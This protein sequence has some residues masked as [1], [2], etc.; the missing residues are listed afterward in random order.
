MMSPQQNLLDVDA[1]TISYKINNT[2]IPAVRDFRLQLQP[3]QI[4]GLVGESGSGK[5]TIAMACMRYLSANGRIEAGSRLNF[6]GEDLLQA[7]MRPL[8]AKRI[9]LVPQ[10]AP[11]ALNPSIKIGAQVTEVLTAA[12][13]IDQTAAHDAMTQ[14]FQDVNLLDAEKVARRYPHE[15]SGGMQQRVLIAMALITN[16]Q[17]LI[18][19][20]PTTGL[21]V[22]TEAVILD[23]IREL[24][25]R[26][27]TGLIYI[28]HNL[29]VVAQLC[30][31]VLVLYGG[32]IMED[33]GVHELYQ[34][35]WHPYSAGLLRSIPKPG[36]NKGDSQLQSIG[37][38]PPAL[39]QLPRGCVFAERCP[40]AIELCHETKPSLEKSAENRLVRCHRWQ[41][42]KSGQL[43]FVSDS[44][45]AIQ[46]PRNGA[47]AALMRVTD[48]SKHFPV[49]RSLADALKGIQP[50]PIRAVDGINLSV[51]SG[52][53]LG[54]VGESGSGKT[55]LARVIIGLQE[56]TG[57]K[58]ELLG[59]DIRSQVRHRS[60]EVLS[61]IQMV[62]QNPQNS[63]NPYLS[64]R[65]TLRRPLIKLRGYSAAAAE[66][67]VLRLLASVNLREEYAERFPD[68][69]SGG[70]KQ[71]VAI[72]RAFA[73][74]PELIL[75]DEP[76]SA[77][78]V[79]VQSAI[80]NLLTQLQAERGS[81]Y[82]FI[83]HDLSLV[84]Y[85]ADAI[86]VMYLGQLVEV[87]TA[88]ELFQPPFHPYTEALV[89]AIP[90]ADPNYKA[91][92]IL[93]SDNLPSAQNLPT[94][95]RFHTRCPRK[96]GDICQ[97]EPPPWRNS[98]GHWIRCHIPLDD[99]H[100]LQR[101][102]SNHS[103]KV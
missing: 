64:V 54:L 62:F 35:P 97:Q 61:K 57:G 41:E 52:H 8:W 49:A 26:R 103:E 75:C 2:W 80:L 93:L 56:R 19:D 48:L 67:E 66:R 38:N 7:D 36:Q 87:G 91:E 63:L 82:L 55:T 81:A 89:S 43:A 99:L 100:Q 92:R 10:N 72:A 47:S 21:D 17:L 76:V 1:L 6:D 25:A 68:E 24:I 70:E 29:G 88:Q 84:G 11:A 37:G 95:C 50:A 98:S 34:A 74:N 65:Q 28:T 13:N 83:S 45:T 94:G 60:K 12:L 3:G 9:K 96:I 42:I 44:A 33:A 71:R 23:L 31:R 102:P 53:T 79:S 73:A 85:L 4:Y 59:M 20:E 27:N 16:P 18:M 40:F 15:L 5:S 77:L 90:V 14:M 39:G 101:Q 30:E 22:T 51:R 69:L 46:H 58:L 78:D 32:E 86:A